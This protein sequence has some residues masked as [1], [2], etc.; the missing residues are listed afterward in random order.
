[1]IFRRTVWL[2][3]AVVFTMTAAAAGHGLQLPGTASQDQRGMKTYDDLLVEVEQ[4]APGFGGMFVD[5]EGRLTVYLLD[6]SQLPAARI[7]IESV[8]G[9]NHV[10]AAGI[11]VLQGQYAISQLKAWAERA[12]AL[13]SMPGVTAVDLDEARNRLTV[14]VE[15]QSRTR[16]VEQALSSR[17][18][19]RKAVVIEV[20]EPIRPVVP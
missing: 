17:R 16:A 3:V 6:T 5:A 14:G 20:I 15:D 8:F 12:T 18:I 13:L 9:T 1:M 7:A 11:R 4:K 2:G 19:P 10:P